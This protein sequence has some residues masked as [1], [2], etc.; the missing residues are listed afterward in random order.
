MLLQVP[1]YPLPDLEPNHLPTVPTLPT[2]TWY[3]VT[4]LHCSTSQ[5]D[6]DTGTSTTHTT[7]HYTALHSRDSLPIRASM[8][9]APSH[10]NR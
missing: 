8:Q 1:L 5:L 9:P 7:L 4:A 2:Y 6:T 3:T 10:H